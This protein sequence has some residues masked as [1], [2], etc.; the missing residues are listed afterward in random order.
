MPELPDILAYMHALEPR[1]TGQP[2]EQIRL[3]SPFV[4]RSVD[5]PIEAA[6]GQV[7][8]AIR[9]IGKRITLELNNEVF[10]VIHLMIAGRLRWSNKP[11]AKPP[12]KIGLA[13]FRFPNGVLHFVESS[14]KKRASLHVVS[15]E[16]NLA[17]HN[18]GGI[19]PLESDLSS[20]TAALS[21][22]RHTLKRALT[23]PRII[24]GV[25]NA[26][27]DEILHAAGLSPFKLTT[28]LSDE[29][30]AHLYNATRNTL[31]HWI[32]VLHN[33]F[34]DKF[35]GAG[36]I[37]AFRDDFAVHGRYGEPCPTCQTKVQRIRYA[38]NETN[39]CPRCQTEGRMLA[40]RSLSRLLKDDW[41][42]TIDELEER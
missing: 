11:A 25:G 24:S 36:D 35:P 2:I 13:S 6:E 7:V 22:H 5:P 3:V 28:S 39:Y 20:F 33:Q 38:E 32:D 23:D 4:L 41:P 37:T 30:W 19:E 17:D 10:L 16:A 15:G 18:P 1:V 31:H 27:S 12:G 42:R 26:Y 9:R 40:D 21:E 14:P 29:E 8:R 34:A